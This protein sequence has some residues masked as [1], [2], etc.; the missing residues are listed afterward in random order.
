MFEVLGLCHSTKEKSP[1][2]PFSLYVLSSQG[3]CDSLYVFL[4]QGSCSLSQTPTIGK[5]SD[6]EKELKRLE[7]TLGHSDGRN[8]K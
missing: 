3:T 1:L 8:R 5:G 4:S 7:R 2:Y 6:N